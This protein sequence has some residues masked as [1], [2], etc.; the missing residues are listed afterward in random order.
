MREKE[1]FMGKGRLKV[2]VEGDV[3][4]KCMPMQFIKQIFTYDVSVS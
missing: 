2:R 3:K 4:M 1:F